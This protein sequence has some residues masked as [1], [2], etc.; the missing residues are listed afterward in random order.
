MGIECSTHRRAYKILVGKP[1]GKSLLGRL[2]NRW[3]DIKI[4]LERYRMGGYGLNSSGSGQGSSGG[5]L[6]FMKYWNL[7][8]S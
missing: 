8:N 1:E 7:L 4:N 3:R 6:D 5:L 2:G